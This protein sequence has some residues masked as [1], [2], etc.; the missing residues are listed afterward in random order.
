MAIF[1]HIVL[2]L[3][4]VMTTFSTQATRLLSSKPHPH[5][6]PLSPGG[7]RTY[8]VLLKTPTGRGGGDMDS[9]SR[10]AWYESFLPTKMT[11]DGQRRLLRS[12]TT[13][14]NGFSA[15][16]THEEVKLVAEKP[17]FLTAIPNAFSYKKTTRTPAFLGL[18]TGLQPSPTWTDANF[19]AGVIIGVVDG[20]IDTHH[21]SLT[22]DAGLPSPPPRWKGSCEG[23]N[24]TKKIIGGKNLIARGMEPKDEEAG[25]GT[26]TATMAAGNQLTGIS[27]DNNGLANGTASGMAPSAHI[28]VY[29]VCGEFG[30]PNDAALEGIDAAVADGV[31][32]INLSLGFPS[33]VTYNHNPIAIGAYG[34]M[35]KGIL[36]VAAG[37]NGGPLPSSVENDVPWMMTVAAGTVDR[38]IQAK[39]LLD[40]GPYHA[41]PIL[42]ES[43]GGDWRSGAPPSPSVGW[44]SL[45]FADEGDR[46]YC[47]YPDDEKDRIR[48]KIVICE[49]EP[50]PANKTQGDEID[51]LLRNNAAG[52]ILIG[53]E[54]D[55][56]TFDLI[57]YGP[58]VMQIAYED[59]YRLKDYASS[60][61][62]KA[63]IELG[64]TILG[65]APAPAVAGLSGRGPSRLSPGILKP[66]LMA[67]GVNILAGVPSGGFEL[68]SGTSASTPHVVGLIAL[69]KKSHPDWSP[70][71]VRSALMTTADILDNAGKPIADQHR[72]MASPYATGA[73][74]VNLGR[75]LDP[76]LIYDITEKDY[77]TYMC[78][79]L[80]KAAY[81][82]VS[83]GGE[84]WKCGQDLVTNMHQCN[85]NYPTITVPLQPAS[86]PFFLYRTVTNVAP[87]DD[88]PET[89][90]IKVDMPSKVR[91]TVEPSTLTFTFPGQK[92]SYRMM[93]SS[94]VAPDQDGVVYQ[95]SVTL[96]SSKH[97]VRSKMIAV[98]GLAKPEPSTPWQI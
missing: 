79:T 51:I 2:A 27:I 49:W 8:I 32:V 36:V 68:K 59:Q 30:C 64:G 86:S 65:Y 44:S 12:Y 46:R 71:A 17:G 96:T 80:G 84:P 57:D 50:E 33:T 70:A 67:P 60:P 94:Y 83:R 73:G 40:G 29:K 19:G 24:C 15:L 11:R 7:Y 3:V 63:S 18:G 90:T 62:A 39:L 66:D 48:D 20:G 21:V 37:G 41:D 87:L 10:R 93:V 22:G 31:D 53:P 6:L 76:G 78:S 42:G 35:T 89:Y 81:E 1:H 43:I 54:K 75:A 38:N 52:V 69:L 88:K 82:A 9:A 72:E 74:H 4:L 47:V 95:G 34:A 55:G 23:F 58:R 61:M 97:T 45:L 91:V 14:V 16:L 5:L 92:I 98:V 28:A 56:Y 26:S 77:A 85:L 13:V 25:H